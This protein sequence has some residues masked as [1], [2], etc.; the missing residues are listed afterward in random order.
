MVFQQTVETKYSLRELIN[1]IHTS[2]EYLNK[3]IKEHDGAANPLQRVVALTRMLRERFRLQILVKKFGKA[4]L[5][6]SDRNIAETSVFVLNNPQY[7]PQ[8]ESVGKQ[9]EKNFKW[10]MEEESRERDKSH[11]LRVYAR[12]LIG[13]VKPTFKSVMGKITAAQKQQDAAQRQ[14]EKKAQQIPAHEGQGRLPEEYKRKIAAWQ[15]QQSQLQASR[16][17]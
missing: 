4:Y 8:L 7:M 6:A 10:V 5:D 16:R 9:I 3:Y 11:I 13:K 14:A 12:N 1:R 15:K 17:R 2:T